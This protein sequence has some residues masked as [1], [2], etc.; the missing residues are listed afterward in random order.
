MRIKLDK[1]DTLFSKMVRER[2][3]WRCQFCL[4]QYEPP[5]NGLQ[6]SHFWGRGNKTTRFDPL[7]CDALCY[8]CHSKHEGNKQGYYREWKTAQIG[9]RA[10]AD[11]ERRARA[12]GK[13]GEYEK[14]VVWSELC[15]QYASGAHL[16]DGWTG[17]RL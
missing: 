4:T 14:R 11:L 9:K 10:Y 12:T 17:V 16:K 1:N 15:A 6:N 8:G 2:D 5:T 7:N 13:Y 3:G